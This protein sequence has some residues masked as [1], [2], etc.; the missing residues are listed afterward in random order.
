MKSQRYSTL[1]LNFVPIKLPTISIVKV[2]NPP[3]VALIAGYIIEVASQKH[4]IDGETHILDI[5]IRETGVSN[6]GRLDEI[7]NLSRRNVDKVDI[8]NIADIIGG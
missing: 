4:I 8:A 5:S 2:I 3:K 1:Q 7:I 6:D